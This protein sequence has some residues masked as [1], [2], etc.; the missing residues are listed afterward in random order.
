MAIQ[1]GLHSTTMF[2]SA[3]ENPENMKDGLACTVADFSDYQ[4][5]KLIQTAV[6]QIRIW[7]LARR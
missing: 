3:R 7:R 1:V 2:V 5:Y 4:I 6:L